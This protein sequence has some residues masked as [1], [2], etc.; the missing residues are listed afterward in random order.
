MLSVGDGM[1]C[2]HMF[3][4][5]HIVPGPWVSRQGMGQVLNSPISLFSWLKQVF[6]SLFLFL[7][8]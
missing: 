2:P 4:G 7:S 3:A 5:K 6:P 1:T 8:P